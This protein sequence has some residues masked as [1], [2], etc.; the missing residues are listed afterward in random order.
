MT[1]LIDFEKLLKQYVAEWIGKNASRIENVQELDDFYAEIFQGFENQPFEEL[2][3]LTPA[4][5]FNTIHNAKDLITMAVAYIDNGMETPAILDR[6]IAD[7]K[8]YK[9]LLHLLKSAEQKHRVYAVGVL[10][11]LPVNG[12]IVDALIDVIKQGRQDEVTDE[13]VMMLMDIDSHEALKL[14]RA[15]DGSD[16]YARD[17][18]MDLIAHHK[19]PNAFDKLLLSLKTADDLSFA[20]Q[21][22]GRLGDERA[23]KPLKDMLENSGLSYYEHTAIREALEDISMTVLHRRD[24]TGDRDYEAV[25]N[26]APPEEE[27]AQDDQQTD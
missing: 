12:Y 21:C 23:I 9:E 15:F 11:R 13:C 2:G 6:R 26:W 3:K 24:F 10:S 14:E 7:L 5:Y 8:L 16:G 4:E 27:D 25:A 20:A 19:T 17:C 22:L 18:F 1:K